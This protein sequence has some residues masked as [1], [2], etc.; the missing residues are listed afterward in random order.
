MNYARFMSNKTSGDAVKSATRALEILELLVTLNRPMNAK[1]IGRLKPIPPSSLSYL[2]ST[3]VNLDYLRREGRNY[4]LGPALARLQLR[5]G[6]DNLPEKIAPI[7]HSIRDRINETCTFFVERNGQIAA[8][9]SAMSSQALQYSVDEGRI[10]PMHAFAAGKALLAQMSDAKLDK[11]LKNAKLEKFTEKTIVDSAEL[12]REIS[13]IKE[14]GFARTA[15]EWTVGI[16]AIARS[17]T[18]GGKTVGALSIAV[19]L[20]RFTA[21]KERQIKYELEQAQKLLA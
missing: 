6:P 10:A 4:I 17:I 8:L 9:V 3:L 16:T 14:D 5:E 19:P 20:A 11:W 13:G 1:D 12:K 7:I 15:E 18:S 21:E 2:L